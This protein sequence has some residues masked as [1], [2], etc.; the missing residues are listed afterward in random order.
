MS[1]DIP[2]LA[3]LAIGNRNQ[4]AATPM[5]VGQISPA[6]L[7]KPQFPLHTSFLDNLI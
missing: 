7:L 1:D 5:G 6:F 4:N 2:D 3:N